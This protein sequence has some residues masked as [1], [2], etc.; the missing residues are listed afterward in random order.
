MRFKDTSRPTR[1]CLL[2]RSVRELRHSC[3]LRIQ[4]ADKLILAAQVSERIA[5]IMRFRD[6]SG[7]T[8][9]SL[10][11]RSLHC[12]IKLAVDLAVQQAKWADA[13][14]LAAQ[15]S[16]T[17]A[18]FMRFRD[19]S[20]TTRSSLPHRSLREFRQPCAIGMQGG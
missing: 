16:E 12:N 3:A 7:T 2:L 13:L 19:A 10:P 14:I 5:A 11:H 4:G 1:S 6:A 20:G 18:A 15:V 9:S 17:I 8:Q